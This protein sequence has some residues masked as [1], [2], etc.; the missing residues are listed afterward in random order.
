MIINKGEPWIVWPKKYSHGLC[1]EDINNSLQGD[2]DFTLGIEFKLLSEG[3]D[4]RTIFSRLPN[5]LGLDIEKENNNVLFII[6]TINNG[7]EKAYYEFSDYS[8]DKDFHRFYIRYSKQK[9]FLD[10]SID[11]KVII[12]VQFDEN[13]EL[14]K[15]DESH[16]ILGSGNFPHNGFNLN[17]SEIEL[18]QFFVTKEFLSIKPYTTEELLKYNSTGVYDFVNRTDYQVWDYTNNYNLIGKIL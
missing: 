3:S 2:N 5:Y 14:L 10:L 18:K 13:E 15:S 7:E 12:E 6:K 16:I 1:K 9:N 8:L 4:K 17:Y 11:G